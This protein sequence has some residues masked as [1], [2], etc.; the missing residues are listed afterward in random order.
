MKHFFVMHMSHLCSFY[1]LLR[2]CCLGRVGKCL[3][4]HE[5]LPRDLTCIL[6]AKPGKLDIERFEPGILFL[7]YKFNHSSN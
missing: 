1:G 4:K 3:L 5:V 7:V 2:F 6:E